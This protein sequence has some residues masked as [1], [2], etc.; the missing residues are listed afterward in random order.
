D[1]KAALSDGSVD[2]RVSYKIDIGSLEIVNFNKLSS[3]N[4]FLDKRYEVYDSETGEIFKK[5]TFELAFQENIAFRSKAVA[6]R[7]KFTKA[8]DLM[9]AVFDDFLG[10]ETTGKFA[11]ILNLVGAGILALLLQA[12]H[13]GTPVD[14]QEIIDAMTTAKQKLESYTE[15]VYRE[16]ISPLVFYI[17]A[18]GLLPDDMNTQ[19][20]T[21]DEISSKYPDLQ[22]SKSEQEGTFFVVGDTVI[23]VYAEN[24]YYSKK[25]VSVS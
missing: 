6:S 18:T 13:A 11:E 7:N 19:T 8:D 3:A 21:A 15:K 25:P 5:P 1:L 12:K 16:K 17:G 24:E 4:Q 23:S 9:K 14:K 2:S 20:M 22:F 10:I